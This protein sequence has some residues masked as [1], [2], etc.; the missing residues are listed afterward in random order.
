MFYL[1]AWKPI[2]GV[3]QAQKWEPT[4]CVI[5]DSRVVSS[6]SSDGTTYRV[7]VKYAYTFRG[8]KYEA[9]RYDF[10]VGSSSGRARKQA[11]VDRYPRGSATTCYVNPAAPG[12]A[13]IERG[14]NR[15]LLIGLFPIPFLLVGVFGFI[16][17]PRMASAKTRRVATTG[18][19]LTRLA[20]NIG[21]G[22]VGGPVQLRSASSPK[23]R[24]FGVLAAAVFWNGITSVFVIQVIAS[25]SRGK[26]EWFLTVFMIP[27]VLIGIGL[28]CAA[29]YQFLNLFN[30]RV[31]L[32]VSKHAVALGEQFQVEW[33]FTG[34]TARIRKLALCLEG[35]EKATYR[36]GTN[37]AT[38]ENIFATVPLIE[39]ED[40]GEIR[41]GT[42]A[43]TIPAE[44]M[45][46]FR[47]HNNEI[48]WR[49]K[50]HGAIPRFPDVKDE[51][52][53]TVLPRP[54]SVP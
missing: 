30:P 37:T 23:A 20:Q 15:G 27:F 17:A 19:D 45:H 2:S 44:L 48:V 36:R 53:I 40:T 13:V 49:L 50:I 31:T 18:D 3:I 16:F 35:V 28:I 6:A 9:A 42:V 54:I 14:F 5:T 8:R 22:S 52:E 41:T 4:P 32:T 33:I 34:R 46:S 51:F 43:A 25:F 12:E 21:A 29:A 1:L 11:I 47:A 38:D 7:D 39:S 24:F 26:P 10:S